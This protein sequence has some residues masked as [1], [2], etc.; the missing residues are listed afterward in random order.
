M[1]EPDVRSG[2][3]LTIE[4]ASNG[5]VRFFLPGSEGYIELMWRQKQK[6][7]IQYYSGEDEAAS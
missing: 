4:N 2:F 5:E 1:R 7:K 3:F 6:N